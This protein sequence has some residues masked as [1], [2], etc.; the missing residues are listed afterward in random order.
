[1]KKYT[2][3][4]KV[5]T[6]SGFGAGLVEAGKVFACSLFIAL[7][8]IVSCKEPLFEG[9]PEE[10]TRFL[11][12]AFKCFVNGEGVEYSD[13]FNYSRFAYERYEYMVDFTFS[14]YI[15]ENHS[16]AGV[17]NDELAF[18]LSLPI[19]DTPPLYN[20]NNYS[21]MPFF[22]YIVGDGKQPFREGV[23]YSNP[24]NIVY[25]FPEGP[26]IVYG[27]KIYKYKEMPGTT[28]GLNGLEVKLL[29]SSFRFGYSQ[30]TNPMGEYLDFYFDFEE[31]ITSVPE[32]YSFSPTVG[33]TIRVSGGH[34]KQCIFFDNIA[35]QFI[36]PDEKK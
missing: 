12:R 13:Y 27:Y 32:G 22:F 24:E 25:Y 23:D 4:G 20:G 35:Y 28:E 3:Q 29:S 18:Y 9:E 16:F 17:K 1:M 5:D 31:V 15:S 33:D 11:F 19:S 2:D 21:H 6:R 8:C 26:W 34:Y 7:L 14:G 10:G 30:D 36:V